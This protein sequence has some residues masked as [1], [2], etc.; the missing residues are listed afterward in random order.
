MILFADS[1]VI[2]PERQI[3]E[4]RKPCESEPPHIR[5]PLYGWSPRKEEMV[6]HLRE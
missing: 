1:S 5:C 4:E 2:V 3:E 6:L